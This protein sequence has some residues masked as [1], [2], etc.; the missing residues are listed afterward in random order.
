MPS[1]E[2]L[3]AVEGGPW[4]TCKIFGQSAEGY[5]VLETD[6]G[7]VVLDPQAAR[8]RI[9][10]EQLM[11]RVQGSVPDSQRL[12]LPETVTLGPRQGALIR[13]FAEAFEEMGIGV[14]ELTPDTF[15]VE[16]MPPELLAFPARTLLADIAQDLETLGAKRGSERWR[17]EV[18]VRAACKAA[19]GQVKAMAEP[20]IRKL[21]DELARCAMPY[22]SPRGRPTMILTSFR[23]L[24]RRF[25]KG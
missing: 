14:A 15:M 1:E 4:W 24:T 6:S 22:T 2:E 17:E 11:L 19:G 18:L 7:L 5:V 9:L 23:E 3:A 10:F 16:S 20:E 25:G 21:I 13:Q 8:E 12:L